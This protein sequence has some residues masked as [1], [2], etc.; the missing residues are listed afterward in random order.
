MKRFRSSCIKSILAIIMT[1]LFILSGNVAGGENPYIASHVTYDTTYDAILKMY[2]RVMAAQCR[3][4]PRRR[5][6][7]YNELM[8][9][10]I[11]M[12]MDGID[13][14]EYRQADEAGKK[15]I[16]SKFQEQ[17]LRYMKNNI[18]YAIRDLNGDGIDEMLIGMKNAY[19]FEVFTMDGGKVR[20]LIKAGYRDSCVLLSD[21]TFFRYGYSG[22][23]LSSNTLFCM[24]GTNKVRFVKG[25]MFNDEFGYQY[26]MDSEDRWFRMKNATDYT[27]NLAKHVSESEANEW[28][29]KCEGNLSDIRFIPFAAYEKGLSG[30]GVAV[31]SKD[32]NTNGNQKI[33]I[34]SKPDNKS[35]IISQKKVGTFV[36]ATGIDGDYYKIIIG[37]KTGY[38]HKDFITL[39][40][41]LPEET[42]K[43]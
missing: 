13:T 42:E 25:Y 29:A 19:V 7:L 38:V 35:K 1:V 2:L 33:R 27:A 26:G 30:D 24:D 22:G 10:D 15:K 14:E 12:F 39:L 8:Y 3:E 32:G 20:E 17:T 6:D 40:T 28:I 37:K 11:P 36:K 34:R 41:D 18:G 5:H 23:G 21:G 9:D 31:L 4:Q 43:Q 16:R